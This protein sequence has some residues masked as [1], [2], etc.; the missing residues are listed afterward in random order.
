MFGEIMK[1]LSKIGE[2]I[3]LIWGGISLLGVI[4][5]AGFVAYQLSFGN[6]A[7]TDVA[8]SRDVRFVLNWCRL[9]D[10]RI[11][12]ILHSYESS[13][14]LTG[15]HLDAYAIKIT[16]VDVSEL[17]SNTDDLRGRWYRGDDLPQI[18]EGAVDYVSG[19]LG[20]NEI[21]WFPKENELR[22]EKIYVYPWSIYYHGVRPTAAQLIFIRLS[23][24]MVFYISGKS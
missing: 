14:S 9:G 8:T 1:R 21:S 19:Y 12:K 18:I 6:R 2:S 7:K 3:I 23:D 22:S 17:T 5:I 15:D 4:V 10:E 11:E 13:R 16:H 24:K 20:W